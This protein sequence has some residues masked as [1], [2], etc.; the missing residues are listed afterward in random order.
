MSENGSAILAIDQGTTNSKALLVSPEGEVL[1]GGSHPVGISSPRLGWFEQDPDELWDSVLQAIGKCLA[2]APGVE[3][4]GVALSNQRESVVAW[5]PATGRPLTRVIGWQDGRAQ[6]LCAELQAGGHDEEVLAAT[7][8]KL[9]PMFSAPKIRWLL[10]ELGVAA[11]G[12]GSALGQRLRLGT[13]DAYLIRRL[14]GSDAIEAGNASRT[15]LFGLRKLD[16]SEELLRLFGI[17]REVLPPVF[18]S[19]GQAAGFG[20]TRGEG[21]LPGGLPLLAVLGDSHAA[22]FGKGISEAGVG[23]ATYGTG[24]SVAVPMAALPQALSPAIS[25]ALV[26]LLE[27]PTYAQEGNIIASGAALDAMARMLGCAGTGALL[28]LAAT[29]TPSGVSFVPAF[30]GLGAPHWDRHAVATISGLSGTTTPAELA[31]AAVDAVAQQVCDVLDAMGATVLY[32][33]GGASVSPLLT[34]LQADLAGVEVR[35]TPVAEASALGV[36]RMAWQ[37]LGDDTWQTPPFTSYQP[38]RDQAWRDAQRARW[39]AAIKQSRNPQDQ[40]KS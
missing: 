36:A 26:W 6:E 20:L 9:D 18:G 35:V 34:Q 33:D 30:S 40:E 22:L 19:T 31:Y 32:A 11:S 7:G 1:A 12:A 23:K 39:A 24:T 10:G 5:D 4:A 38:Q 14:T 37:C 2:Q 28:E 25:T 17:P 15:L 21:P 3:L 27:K 29:A 13:I 8:L 16:W